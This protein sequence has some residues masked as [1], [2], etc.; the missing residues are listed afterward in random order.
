MSMFE[1]VNKNG[2]S[3]DDTGKLTQ[4]DGAR[5]SKLCD[6]DQ[7]VLS[8]DIKFDGDADHDQNKLEWYDKVEVSAIEK[9]KVGFDKWYWRRTFKGWA[10]KVNYGA[11]G[12]VLNKDLTKPAE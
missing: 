10:C 2:C 6:I 3:I 8:L 1:I 12:W 5:F 4:G 11:D 7:W 9:A